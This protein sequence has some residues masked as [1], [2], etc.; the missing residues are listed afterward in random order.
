MTNP[1]PGERDVTLIDGQVV[2]NYS[3]EWRFE[4][5]ARTVAQKPTRGARQDFLRLVE[6]KQGRDQRARL[7][8]YARAIYEREGYGAKR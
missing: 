3:P 4:C 6:Q 1:R 5:L 2:S 7:E 8:S